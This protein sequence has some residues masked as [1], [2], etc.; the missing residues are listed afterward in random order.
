MDNC[1]IFRKERFH[2][3]RHGERV[4]SCTQ[5][6]SRTTKMSAHVEFVG[7]ETIC[8]EETR[9][10]VSFVVANLLGNHLRDSMY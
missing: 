1:S 10:N 3:S 5:S 2:K 6:S 9:I 4:V 7:D 8:I